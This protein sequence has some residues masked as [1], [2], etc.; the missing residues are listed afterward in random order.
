MAKEIGVI[1]V[2]DVFE[3]QM[4]RQHKILVIASDGIWGV[5]TN[6]EVMTIAGKYYERGSAQ[7]ACNALVKKATLI[8]NSVGESMDDITAIV[9]FL[10]K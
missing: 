9:V 3:L 2:P 1:S 7:Q 5:L 10:N 8:W 4:D 6:E